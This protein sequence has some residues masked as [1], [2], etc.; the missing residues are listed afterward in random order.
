MHT[1]R[2]LKVETDND[3]EYV[4]SQAQSLQI[5]IYNKTWKKKKPM[6][7]ARNEGEENRIWNIFL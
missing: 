1:A 3:L 5:W 2:D 4:N 6:G 7:E